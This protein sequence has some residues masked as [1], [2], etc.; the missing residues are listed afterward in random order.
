MAIQLFN[1]KKVDAPGGGLAR[2]IMGGSRDGTSEVQLDVD[3]APLPAV[4]DLLP[5]VGELRP[6][7]V[8][9]QAAQQ[10]IR[11]ARAL[12]TS[13]PKPQPC[14]GIV[15]AG[16]PAYG[17]EEAWPQARI[18]AWAVQTVEW[19]RQC[20]PHAIVTA[21]TLHQDETRPHV[22]VLAVARAES[23]HVGWSRILPGFALSGGRRGRGPQHMSEL[24]T[25]YHT[26][27]AAPFGLA[28]DRGEGRR[29]YEPKPDRQQAELDRAAAGR[30]SAEYLTQA[31][32][33]VQQ[34]AALGAEARALEGQPEAAPGERA[35]LTL[36]NLRLRGQVAD[37]HL[38]LDQL[39]QQMAG[40]QGERD[41]ALGKADQALSEVGALSARQARQAQ[42]LVQHVQKEGELTAALTEVREEA[43]DGQVRRRELSTELGAVQAE[44]GDVQ[45]ER[46]QLRGAVTEAQAAVDALP[47]QAQW[48]GAVPTVLGDLVEWAGQWDLP[49]DLRA[50]LPILAHLQGVLG[51][52][53]VCLDRLRDAL[54]P[55]REP[56]RREP[57]PPEP[58]RDRWGP[59]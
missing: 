32:P 7:E 1:V 59:G 14:V 27:V 51:V 30:Y 42:A 36:A 58:R 19:F 57:S 2:H 8:R 39:E 29:A 23:G 38:R 18:E 16:P 12:R 34:V 47:P 43:L 25:R 24:Q 9:L 15:A 45:A 55:V 40:L 28:R 17:S 35:Q 11:E 54:A 50:R 26:E 6:Y 41:A 31:S 13:G 3:G 10:A 46:T 4:V 44:L 20:A 5:A 52:V 56:A 53:T 21:A 37:M 49:Q 48:L 33:A 22:H